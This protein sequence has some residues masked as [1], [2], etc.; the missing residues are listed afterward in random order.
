MF[1]FF[2]KK[3]QAEVDFSF[4][5]TDMHSHLIAGID[6]GAKS[7]EDA[8]LMIRALSGM[9]F[10]KIITTPHIFKDYYPNTPETILAG[11]EKIKNA[12]V[13][14]NLA[15]EIEA[16]AEYYM[17]YY[18]E[19]LLSN[20]EQLLT[21]DKN[22]VLVEFSTFAAPANAHKMIFKLKTLGYQ[23]VLAHPERYIYFKDAV[24]EIKKIRDYGCFLQ[25]NLLSLSGYYGAKQKS[26]GIKLIKSGIVDYLGTDLH[27]IK[28]LEYLKA[29][30][31]NKQVYSLMK[32]HDF[33]NSTF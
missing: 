23:P 8:M 1:S 21:L 15:I 5:H 33:K 26:L 13:K 22:K 25:V 4:L 7:I 24:A 28:Q 10:K 16:A 2:R 27:N 29:L 18:L 31:G 14:A 12:I 3:F 6:D 17:D 20:K 19:E 32:R 9:G 30:F 11:L